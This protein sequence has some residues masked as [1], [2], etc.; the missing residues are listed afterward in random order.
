MSQTETAFEREFEWTVPARHPSFDGHF[1]GHPI[2]PGVVLLDHL[3]L[4]LAANG[5]KVSEI[6]N[7]KFSS[8]A[9]AGERLRFSV[10]A[11]NAGNL[12][13]Q[14][15]CTDRAMALIASGTLRIAQDAL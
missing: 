2:L 3:Q 6:S 10:Q 11:Q 15:A 14:I 5:I 9:L 12:R 8:P 7:A 4:G 1:P 13:F